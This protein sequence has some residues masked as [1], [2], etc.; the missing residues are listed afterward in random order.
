M[1]RTKT[2]LACARALFFGVL[3][4]GGCATRTKV[5]ERPDA[6]ST[7][8]ASGTDA[9]GVVVGSG[10]RIGGGGANPGSGGLGA[11]TGGGG[12][13]NPGGGG[14]GV[15]TGGG[16]GTGLGGRSCGHGV[17]TGQGIPTPVFMELRTFLAGQHPR[18]VKLG[19]LNGDG[20]G[21]MVV[22]DELGV[23]VLF[24][25]TNS[26]FPKVVSYPLAT[27][28]IALVDIDGDGDLDLADLTEYSLTTALNDG[29][30]AFVAPV[31]YA[32]GGTSFFFADVNADGQA[33][34]V[35]D[36]TSV[37]L[38][39]GNRT[40]TTAALNHTFA[41]VDSSSRA[42]LAP[43]TALVGDFDGDGLA[44]LITAPGAGE[45]PS[46]LSAS[47]GTSTGPFAPAVLIAPVVNGPLMTRD[48]NG[49]CRN[50]VVGYNGAAVSILVN[51][52]GGRFAVGVDYVFDAPPFSGGSVLAMGDLNGDG[53]PD[54]AVST[55]DT[56]SQ[57]LHGGL[58]LLLNDGRAGFPTSVNLPTGPNVNSI[59]IAD[60]N[61][62]GRLDIAAAYESGVDLLLNVTPPGAAAGT[63]DAGIVPGPDAAPL[64]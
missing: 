10:G 53:S 60:V 14:L 15:G 50:D 27:G 45:P 32:V 36:G 4:I 46:G 8:G 30:G 61:G 1:N 18:S 3:A 57:D 63:P 5:G 24:N 19:D 42:S 12:S 44:D 17:T 33:D 56:S 52:G 23:N 48:L 37:L 40:F 7:G 47:F 2:N 49:D 64:D 55:S 26:N 41:I 29:K 9:G 43:D 58:G 39:T 16:G 25:D 13:G 35:V 34:V 22:V 20:W 21:D 54:L 6:G 31:T 62:D 28:N 59:A 38:G 11:G 51:L